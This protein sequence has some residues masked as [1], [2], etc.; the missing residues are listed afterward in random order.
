LAVNYHEETMTTLTND[1]TEALEKISIFLKDPTATSFLL[2]GGA[3]VGKTF[4]LGR[5]LSSL[6]RYTTRA[7][8]AP[9]H[10]AINVLR[11]KLD[12][13]GVEWCLGF[14]DYTFNGT[15]VITG[16]TAQL[17][18][19]S[20]VITEDQGTEVKFGKKGKG[21]LS[22]IMPAV[23]IID[24]ASMLGRNDAVDLQKHMK[25]AGCKLIF[26]G[27]AGQL[28]PVKQEAIPFDAFK[29]NAKL[30]Q[31]VRQAEGSKIIELAW[32]IRE[33]KDWSGING[34]GLTKTKRIAE[35]F[36]DAVQAPG[37]RPEEAREVFIAY[38]NRIVNAMQERTCQKLYGHAAAAFAP[39]ELVLSACNFYKAKTL[40]CS[41]QDELS[42]DRF[43]EDQRDATIGVPVVLH[44]RGDPRKGKFLAHYLSPEEMADKR[45]PYNVELVARLE[46][47]QKLQEE[48]KKMSKSDIFRRE[49]DQL[50]RE[51][52]ASY[53]E[54]RDNT[55]ISF[56]H[57]FAITSHKS[58]GSTYRQVFA[59]TTDL[60][61]FSS[62]ALYVAVTRPKDELV[63][64]ASL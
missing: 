4:L 41:N 40:L 25:A 50:R 5:L 49:K 33:G 37:E 60:G 22:K 44:H 59:D 11:R 16:T 3:G 32:A 30:R 61:R 10:K 18:G 55:V 19:I 26:V 12:G 20:P 64:P 29:H 46:K 48:I 53:F 7:V 56:R 51:A 6:D 35:Q 31:I 62:H 9:T 42:V 58:Q 43:E 2:E 63:I 17:L 28:P 27:D 23:T 24:E 15:D 47:A 34:A 57:P 21:I 1:Q 45:H 39:G 54:W 52:W 13:F 36:L 8:A 14:D 38:T